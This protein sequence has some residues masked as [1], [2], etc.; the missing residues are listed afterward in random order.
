MPIT[1][2]LSLSLSSIN[3]TQ[4]L[5]IVYTLTTLT[6]LSAEQVVTAFNEPRANCSLDKKEVSKM[7]IKETIF[8]DTTGLGANVVVS[9]LAVFLVIDVINLVPPSEVLDV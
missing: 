6:P 9:G 3:N 8:H 1:L 2:S 4:F 5:F 7:S